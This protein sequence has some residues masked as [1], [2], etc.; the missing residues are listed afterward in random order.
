MTDTGNK[1]TSDDGYE[2]K[3]ISIGKVIITIVISVLSLAVIL[4]LL[5]SY[6]TASTEEQI[7]DAVLRPESAALREL[8]AREEETL[9][10]YG[11]LDSAA[12]AYRIPIDRAMQLMADEAFR[13]TEKS[14]GDK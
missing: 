6:F 13:A 1:M 9:N 8:R 5:N 3:D 10:S 2:K 14:A 4:V 7:Y 11:R 12:G